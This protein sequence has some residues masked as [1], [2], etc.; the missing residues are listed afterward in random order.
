MKDKENE[1]GEHNVL[2]L[3][4]SLQKKR[5]VVGCEICDKGVLLRYWVGFSRP[6]PKNPLII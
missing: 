4:S 3:S 1:L 2:Q 6:L 5:V